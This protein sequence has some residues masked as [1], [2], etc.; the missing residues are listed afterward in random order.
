MTEDGGNRWVGGGKD[1]GDVTLRK[2]LSSGMSCV[3]CEI[4]S[5]LDCEL[6]AC[7]GVGGRRVDQYCG[8]SDRSKLSL[9]FSIGRYLLVEL[10]CV[11]G[12]LERLVT[13][14]VPDLVA[15]FDIGVVLGGVASPNFDVNNDVVTGLLFLMFF[16]ALVDVVFL[17]F[18]VFAFTG[19]LS[20]SSRF[21]CLDLLPALQQLQQQQSNNRK[22]TVIG[23]TMAAISLG[24]GFCVILA[25]EVVTTQFDI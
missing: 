24:E 21:F 19:V 1:G 15:G 13:V 2:L 10:L 9:A 4:T 18:A 20:I 5:R 3:R 22:T 7:G 25:G 23:T 6:K 8:R 17:V 16:S 11:T 12:R 14:L